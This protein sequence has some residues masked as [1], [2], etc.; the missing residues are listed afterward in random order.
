[1]APKIFVVV[2]FSFKHCSKIFLGSYIKSAEFV[3][4]SSVSVM[5][6]STSTN[7]KIRSLSV[8]IVPSDRREVGT[9]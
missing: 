1:V 3:A 8:Q 6:I 5:H 7:S 9:F 2:W 4:Y